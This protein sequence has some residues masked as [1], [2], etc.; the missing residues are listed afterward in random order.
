MLRAAEFSNLYLLNSQGTIIR[1]LS[2]NADRCRRDKVWLNHWMFWPR[3]G[4]DGKTL[5]FSYDQ[6][7]NSS[8]AT[9]SISRSGRAR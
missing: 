4:A 1:R 6:P 9:R 3:F 2:N 5:Y 8:D 7:K